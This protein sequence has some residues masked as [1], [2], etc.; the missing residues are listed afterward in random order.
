MWLWQ[1]RKPTEDFTDFA[2]ASEDTNNPNDHAHDHD[3]D[4]EIVYKVKRS[5]ALWQIFSIIICEPAHNGTRLRCHCNRLFH[6]TG[7]YKFN[8]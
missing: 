1:I 8:Y 5:D 7:Q 2:P 3:D 6:L 4:L